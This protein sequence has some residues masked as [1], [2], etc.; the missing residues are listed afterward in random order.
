MIARQKE[1]VLEA[2]RQMIDIFEY[3]DIGLLK[4]H[5]ECKVEHDQ[6][7]KSCS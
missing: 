1:Q 2:K 4:E 7:K 6:K 5:V 3:E